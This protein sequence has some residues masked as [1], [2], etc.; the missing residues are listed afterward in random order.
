M[1]HPLTPRTH[2]LI[3][4]ATDISR[5]Y[6]ASSQSDLALLI[7]MMEDRDGIA[8][9]ILSYLG[10]QLGSLYKVF[11]PAAIPADAGSDSAPATSSTTIEHLLDSAAPVATESGMSQIGSEHLLVVMARLPDSPAGQAL[12][13]AGI[14]E[15][16]IRDAA[17]RLW[18]SL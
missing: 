14:T 2:R 6:G 5:R 16:R 3:G 8:A 15:A 18:P 17:D 7:A 11:P 12:A 1:P 9:T 13:T 4:L 10:L